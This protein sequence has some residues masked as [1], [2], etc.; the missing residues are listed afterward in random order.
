V[1][2]QFFCGSVDF[3]NVHSD[4]FCRTVSGNCRC[5]TNGFYAEKARR[6]DTVV[7]VLQSKSESANLRNRTA[8]GNSSGTTALVGIT[9]GYCSGNMVLQ[10]PNSVSKHSY[11]C[12]GM[13]PKRSLPSTCG[14][15]I[16]G[17]HG[18]LIA[19]LI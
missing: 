2:I 6:I 16:T 8:A 7:S 11:K 13:S 5:F 9:N 15:A 19:H 17:A 3:S 1:C 12:F 10:S 4:S 14:A 18:L